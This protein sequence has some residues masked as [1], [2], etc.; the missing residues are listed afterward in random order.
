LSFQ[1]LLGNQEEE[2]LEILN[3]ER[4]FLYTANNGINEFEKRLE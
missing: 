2:K 3:F 4:C 1:Q